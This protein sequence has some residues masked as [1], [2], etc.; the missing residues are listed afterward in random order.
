[1]FDFITDRSQSHIDRLN[2]L[3]AK[4][5]AN[6]TEAEQEEWYDSAAK[7]AYNYS[8][9][10]R[11]ESAVKL[12]ATVLGLELTTKTDWG[13]WDIPTESDMKRYLSNV[14]AI[15][16]A[17][18]SI[19]SYPT[20]PSSMSGLTFKM[21]NNIE[22]VLSLVYDEKVSSAPVLGA[23]ILGQTVISS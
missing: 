10:N 9:L 1:M 8:D 18:T 6:M 5:W 22:K 3:H 17:C 13:L 7:G 14:V 23:M 15:R 4:G 12:L 2:R 16:D 20:L 19:T 11:V 21:A